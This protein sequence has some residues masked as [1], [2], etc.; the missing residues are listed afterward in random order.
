MTTGNE[1]DTKK[2]GLIGTENRTESVGAAPAGTGM[3]SQ[4]GMGS[5]LE[6]LINLILKSLRRTKDELLWG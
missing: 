5:S 3:A 1:I 4:L 2:E 6:R